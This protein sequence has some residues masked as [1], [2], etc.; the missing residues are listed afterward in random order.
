MKKFTKFAACF[1][2]LA[3]TGC[4]NEPE[5]GVALNQ[6]KAEQTLNPNAWYEN[7]D[8]LPKGSGERTQ[9]SLKVYNS[10]GVAKK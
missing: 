6:L 2:T 3:L 4:A 9:R 1:A 5:L 7:I 8:Y 10:N